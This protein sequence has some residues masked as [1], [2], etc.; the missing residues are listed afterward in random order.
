M[1]VHLLGKEVGLGLGLILL[2][3]RFVRAERLGQLR[4]KLVFWVLR[5]SVGMI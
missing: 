2:I 1:V 5:S 4:V 3:F